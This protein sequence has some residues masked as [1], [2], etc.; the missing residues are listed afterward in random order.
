MSVSKHSNIYELSEYYIIETYD[1]SVG[2]MVEKMYDGFVEQAGENAIS[3]RKSYFSF[4]L[5]SDFTYLSKHVSIY[6]HNS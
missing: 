3:Q 2:Q 1:S 5:S 4:F 6:T